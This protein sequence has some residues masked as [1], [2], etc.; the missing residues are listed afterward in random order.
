MQSPNTLQE[1]VPRPL[2]EL[3]CDPPVQ[4]VFFD[5][6]DTFTTDGLLLPEALEAL[7]AWHASGR[8]SVAVT[9]RP[10]GWCDH[11]AR[12]WPVDAVVGENGAF[13][14]RYD[15]QQH[16]M[17]RRFVQDEATLAGHRARFA[18]LGEEVLAQVPG[19][20]ISADQPYR[21]CD[22]AIDFAEDVRTDGLPTADRVAQ[23][24]RNAG[25]R[26]KIS[27]IHVN[28]WF[29][30]HDK[31]STTLQMAAEEFG[32]DADA[33]SRNHLYLGDSPND[34]PMFGFF[35]RSV[36]VANVLEYG[37]RVDPMPAYVCDRR[38]GEGFA[39]ALRHVIG[40]ATG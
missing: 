37:G 21:A 25:M 8:L 28:A 40:Y 38:S 14:F 32:M 18:A 24:L 36:G 30:D 2:A 34:A 1:P 3:P 4:G 16:R 11:I 31:L 33:L 19:V 17:R 29:G 10:A 9:G 5:I 7:A 20:A 26:V 35:D 27:S 39:Q 12:M 15:R 13:W 22:L 6:D 23:L